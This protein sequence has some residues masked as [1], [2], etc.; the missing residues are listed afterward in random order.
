MPDGVWL[1]RDW[2]SIVFLSESIFV[3]SEPDEYERA[4]RFYLE[5]VSLGDL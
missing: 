3:Y 5:G 2:E 4:R 1:E